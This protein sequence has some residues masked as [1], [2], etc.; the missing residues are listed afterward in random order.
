MRTRNALALTALLLMMS[1]SPVIS[2]A[3]STVTVNTTWSGSMTLTGNVTVAQ[4]ATLTIASGTSVDA[5]EYGIL[6][7]GHLDAEEA[8]FF[9]SVPPLTQGS[10]G[11]GLWPGI[12]IA[13]SGSAELNNVTVANA[14]AALLVRGSLEG[15]DLVLNDAYRGLSLLGGQA[16]LDGVDAHRMDYEAFYVDGGSLTLNDASAVE[17]AVGMDLNGQVNASE[18]TVH[19]AGVGIR[20]S[21]GYLNATGIGIVNASVGLATKAGACPQFQAY[22]PRVS[23]SALMQVIPTGSRSVTLPCRASGCSLRKE[24]PP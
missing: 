19:E 10:H 9:S 4:G 15:S 24:Q 3:D 22:M 21:G 12:E 6:V 18:I 5:G 20:T 14:S 11:Q 16:T 17:V 1:L 7:E 13:S 2:A 8:V 23:L